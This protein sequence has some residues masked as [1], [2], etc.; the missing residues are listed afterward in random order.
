ML[1]YPVLR[2]ADL[3]AYLRLRGAAG[4]L[5]CMFRTLS[6][7]GSLVKRLLVCLTVLLACLSV[8]AGQA[9]LLAMSASW[10]LAWQLASTTTVLLWSNPVYSYHYNR[11]ANPVS[12]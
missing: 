6:L 10:Q 8:P 9:V 5:P 3:V 4:V 2:L 1:G 11:Y 7:V 12:A